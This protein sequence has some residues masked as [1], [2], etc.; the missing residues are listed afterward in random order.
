M[1][2][3]SRQPSGV[4]LAAAPDLARIAFLFKD[5]QRQDPSFDLSQASWLQLNDAGYFAFFAPSATRDWDGFAATARAAFAANYQ[6]QLGWFG[7]DAPVLIALDWSGGAPVVNQPFGLAFRQS[8]TLTVTPSLLGGNPTIGFD[9]AS[10]AFRIDNTD[11]TPDIF[12]LTATPPSGSAVPY[13]SSGQYAA[14]PV[15]GDLAGTLALPFKLTTNDLKQFEAGMMY[16]TP[17]VGGGLIGA[18]TYPLFR[19]AGAADAPFTFLVTLDV[20]APLDPLRSFFQFQDA[21]IGTNYS[22]VNGKPVYFRPGNGSLATTARFVFAGRPVQSTGD[23]DYYYL[24]P[25]GQFGV[26]LSADEAPLDAGAQ[27]AGADAGTRLLCG[28]TGTEFLDVATAGTADRLEFVPA[29]PAY[30]IPT[31]N[32]VANA[33]AY[34]NDAATTSYARIVTQT[35]A[36]VSQPQSAPLY[37]QASTQSALL[38]GEAPQSG[39]KVHL[40]DFLPIDSWT[41]AQQSPATPFVPYGG[42]AFATDPNLKLGDYLAMETEALNP[43]RSRAYLTAKPQSGAALRR[44]V[45]AALAGDGTTI[46][47]TPQ[48]MLA[49][50]SGTPATW[51]QLQ[52]AISAA[53]LLAFDDMGPEIVQAVQQNQIFTVISAD[54]GALFGF[55]D[56][57]LTIGDWTFDLSPGGLAA[58]DG[59]P[60][61]FLMKFYPDSSIE[62]LVDDIRLWSSPD[63]FNSGD[64]TAEDAQTYLQKLIADARN[65]VFPDGA[66]EPDTDSLYYNFYEVVTDPAFSGVLAVNCNMQLETLPGAI[67]AVLGGMKDPG[68]PGF[69]VHHVGVAI[70]NTDPDQSTPTLA[71][72]ATFALVDYEK[73]ETASDAL[74]IDVDYGFEVEFLRALFTN[75]E[76]R[77]FACQLNLTINS[78]FETGVN[79]DGG[80]TAAAGEPDAGNTITIIGSYQAHSTSGDDSNSGEGIY[81]FVAQGEFV[82]DF[83]DKDGEPNNK[84][85]KSITLTKLQFSFDDETPV[86]SADANDSVTTH[87]SSHFGIW[88]YI[89]FNEL[90]VLDIFSF[91]KLEFSDLGINVG[92]DLTIPQAGQPSTANLA[93]SFSPGNLRLDLGA[94]EKKEG[95]NSLLSLI[96]FKLKSFLYA[97]GDGQSIDS[98]D[99]YSLSDIAGLKE[100][101]ITLQDRF[102]Y[103]LVF[104]LDLGS[105][106]GLVGSLSAFQFSMVIGWLNPAQGGGLAFGVQL[107]QVDGKLEIKIQGVL[108]ISI[109]QF[110]LLYATDSDPKMLVLGLQDC[111]IDVLGTRVPPSGTISIGLFAPTEGA[112][113]IGW[114]GAYNKGEDGGGGG[115][116]GGEG[117]DGG[118]GEGGNDTG[119]LLAARP[120]SRR[121]VQM[122]EGAANADEGGVFELNYVG[123]GQRVG[124]DPTDPP[125]SYA[126]FLDYMQ[127]TFW[128]NLKDKEF[129]EIY[130]PNGRWIFVADF[131]LLKL[132]QIGTV[133]YDVTPF[134]ALQISLIGGA[135]K[136]F[137]FEITYTKVTDEIGLYAI[138]IALPD[139]LRTFQVGVAS[140]TLPT[141]SINIYT[142]G[143]WKVDLGFPN[144]DDWSVCFRVQAQAG[145][146]PVTGSGGFYI[147]SLSSATDPDVF[148]GTYESIAAFGFALRLGVG[149]DFVAGPLKAGVSVTFFGIIQGAAG[150][151]T[152]G[153]DIFRTPDALSLQGQIGIIGELYG[154]VD[155][156]IIKAS[157]N[158]RL[159]ASI[160]LILTYEPK[161]PGGGDGS[162]LL[163]IEA[164]V[165]VSVKVEINLFLFKV[166]I[167]F[168]FKASFRFEWQLAGSS[169]AKTAL[170]ASYRAAR[171][172]AAPQPIG[173]CP[174]LP[175]A[176]PLLY[177]PEVTVVFANAADAGLPW[178]AVSLGIEYDP[179]PPQNP[180]YSAFKPFEAVTTQLATFALMHALELDSYDSIVTLEDPAPQ[181]PGLRSIDSD[182]DLL[183]GWIGYG[184]LLAQLGNFAGTLAQPGGSTQATAFPMPPF[185]QLATDGRSVGADPDELS[186]VFQS[187]NPV[188]ASY[189]LEVDAYFNQLFVDQT[190]TPPT[191]GDPTAETPLPVEIFLDYFKGLIRGAVHQLLVTM[192]NQG[193]TEAK[194]DS[195]FSAAAGAPTPQSQSLFQQLAGQMSSSMRAGIRLPKTSGLTLPGGLP[196]QDTNPLFALLWQEFPIGDFANGASYTIILSNPSLGSSSTPD[197]S[198]SWAPNAAPFTLT[199]PSISAYYGLTA[200]AVTQPGAPVPIDF[201]QLGPQSFAFESAI[202]WTPASGAALSL[203]PFPPSLLRLQLAEG[204]VPIAAV[205]ASRA[206]DGP[207][208]P[209]GTPV[210]A[211][212]VAF[213]TSIGLTVRQIPGA[214]GKPLDDVFAL[215]GASQS[216]EALLGRILD[217]LRAGDRP[218]ASI[219][220]LYQQAAGAAGL[221]SATCDPNSVFVLRTNTSSVS[222][223][224]Q[225]QAVREAAP[226]PTGVAVGATA[227]LTADGGYGFL[228]IVQQATVTNASGYY[229]RYQDSAGASLPGP[230]FVKGV[231]QITLLLRYTAAAEANSLASPL[232]IA[233]YHNAVVLANTQ[234]GLVYYA[235]ATDP[236]LAIRYAATSA[237]TFGVTLSRSDA[238]TQLSATASIAARANIAEAAPISRSDAIAAARA[239]GLCEDDEIHALLGTLGAAPAAL[240]ALYSLVTYRI[241]KTDGFIQS[242]L[243]APIQPQRPNEGD[244][245]SDYRIIAPLY[246]VAEANQQ[247][248]VSDRYASIAKPFTLSFFTNDAFGNQMPTPGSYSDTNLYFDPI[249][250][251]DQWTGI[252]SRYDFAGTGGPAANQVSL[253]LEPTCTAFTDMSDDERAAA[254]AHFLTI[255]DQ[256]TGP[257]V[258]F[259]V[260][261]S[262]AIDKDGNL[263]PFRLGTD[264]SAKIVAMVAGLA[265]WLAPKSTAS[266]PD[267]VR[268]TLTVTGSGDLPPLFPLAMLFGIQRDPDL[269]SP[270]IKDGGTILLPSAQNVATSLAPETGES[271]NLSAFAADFVVA[272][273]AQKLAVG[274]TGTDAAQPP[275]LQSSTFRARN[276]LRSQ[277][278]ATDGS[279]GAGPTGA[280]T[281][282]AAQAAMLDIGI[283]TAKDSGP[284]YLSPKPLDNVLNTAN[285]PLPTLASTLPQLP[286]QRLFV[287]IDLD[288]Y[289]R[290]FF[291]TVDTILGPASAAQAFEQARAAYDAIARGRETLAHKYSTYEVDWLFDPTSPFSGSDDQRIVARDVFEQQMRASL[292]TAHAVDTIVQYDVAWN[293]SV[294]PAA[295]QMI[296]LFGQVEAIIVGRY[297]WAGAEL[298]ATSPSASSLSVGDRVLMVFTPDTG[299]TAPPDG[300]YTVATA[301]AGQFTVATQNG[302][303]KGGFSAT[304]QNSGLSTAHVAIS[305]SGTSPLTFLYG[306]PDVADRAIVTMDLR[307]NITNL[308]YFLAPPGA[309]GEARP[310]LWLQLIDPYAP[311]QPPHIG[312]DG[313][314]TDIPVVFRQYPTP[315]TMV[316]QGWSVPD[317]TTVS[318][319]P[320]AAHSQWDYSYVYQAF[321]AA[322]DRINSAITYNTDLSVAAPPSN[323][324]VGAGGGITV[325]DLFGALARANAVIDAI[326]PVLQV[327]TDPNWKDAVQALADS[328]VEVT[329]NSTW[330]PLPSALATAPLTQVTDSYVITDAGEGTTQTIMLTWPAAQGESSFAGVSLSLSALDPASATLQPYPGQ[331][332]TTSSTALQV[333]VPNAPLGRLGVV[334]QVT[335]N[336][337]NVLAAENALAAVQVERNLISLEGADQQEWEVVPKFIYKTAQVRP[338]QPVTPFIDVVAPIDVATLPNLGTGPSCP[339]ATAASLCQRVYTILAN[340][341]A[342]PEQ[343]TALLEAYQAAGATAGASRRMKMSCALRFPLAAVSGTDFDATSPSPLVPVVM[344]RS[345]DIDGGDPAQ[346]GDFASLFAQAIDAWAT[347]NAIIYGSQ[348]EP[349]GAKLVF[350]ATLYAALSGVDTPVLRFTSLE[351]ALTDIDAV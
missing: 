42:L 254:R 351:L 97:T 293:Q 307:F 250:P 136:G 36:Y 9:D 288:Q 148:K 181:K 186:Y 68:I 304:R 30:R 147:A 179:A 121:A 170:L 271:G 46:A 296:E 102:N 260:E 302:T 229:L 120:Q 191:I 59:T 78:L 31:G 21:V 63:V 332:S 312:P 207:Y 294:S 259:Y 62:D 246:N 26:S 171:R 45:P 82:Y 4:Y 57:K 203:Q 195:L 40:L 277:G 177:L 16:F 223:P 134:Y 15:T 275:A 256:I 49:G 125:T 233:P 90:K 92:F 343:S 286:A 269:I 107:P 333:V 10:S 276:R 230:L 349:P 291:Q 240:N 33:P 231:G 159:Q 154:S 295:D 99:Y 61:I 305:T 175:A 123:L 335:A 301:D 183:T 180:P 208:L 115:D 282:W 236:S 130:H 280:Q 297:A 164:S 58:P 173:L 51:T 255:G 344:A 137:S 88:G 22:S 264:D 119:T 152:S 224:P 162:I 128:D 300:I 267:P 165:S 85:L 80:D 18:L 303:G 17:P 309:E 101:G 34:L 215:S 185:L 213:V 100:N 56:S 54:P 166:T 43:K 155:F 217:D 70:N 251:L 326:R 77:S 201:T 169:T 234:P 66:S 60:P 141:I 116:T 238:V 317:G 290:A 129:A 279:T 118:G 124:P 253:T 329:A 196:V 214:D 204:K 28:L 199:K 316:R 308:Q 104:D 249:I 321:L 138:T 126:E 41:A 314:L 346:L 117:G 81:S 174:G 13:Y 144:G 73:A 310:S 158:V 283:G 334:Q 184:D 342:D 331:T 106:G 212:D 239:S 112:D 1:V 189:L 14:L 140:V 274:L 38:A 281:L 39:L 178:L 225:V 113:Q 338:S 192:Q 198:K 328:V 336:D 218:I 287:D 157:V 285:V 339:S 311:G 270:Y 27:D 323:R 23:S 35:G 268:I 72:S 330:N 205:V 20:L 127:T 74:A 244:P 242:Y 327:P 341:L 278:L 228:Q 306:T 108:T 266:F 76:L 150:Y 69:R 252:V 227:D 32:D 103:A 284:R 187:K 52:M 2:T 29:Q 299:T 6:S 258:S 151:L 322:Q 98:I 109:E 298:T 153:G 172:L 167:S 67:R 248:G 3:F 84:Y 110:T 156:V 263:V 163:Y 324:A 221:S 340:L 226:L 114:I 94:T 289:N 318:A 55:A 232:A 96:P 219:E 200:G 47:M 265:A 131:T 64:F 53:G 262:L 261:T 139:T 193:L 133:F 222:Q 24:T 237:G 105:L 142:N 272:F 197:A 75:S 216:D 247:S 25:A 168:S 44:P 206:A 135:G 19:S 243:S 50:I 8:V 91:E 347:Q 89:E 348:S 12:V 149:K 7:D 37:A 350:D 292:M 161:A 87:I 257:G 160:G 145:P 241:E 190:P 95:D 182:P 111:F 210:P 65:A 176:L 320:I 48:G 313:V 143:N 5:A 146:V 315:P 273:P 86:V 132:I 345:F 194:L 83:T 202:V 122:F 71:Q 220:I 79:Q 319:N 209:D 337:L 93:L 325:F 245:D 11:G 235:E 211:G 188:P